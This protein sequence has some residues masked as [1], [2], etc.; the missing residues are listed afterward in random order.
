[1]NCQLRGKKLEDAL[2][3]CILKLAKGQK[4]YILNVTEVSRVSGIS[5][6][7]IYSHRQIIDETL[8]EI[9]ASR[10]MS[11]GH[12]TLEHA[13]QKITDLEQQKIALEEQI[14]GYKAHH[15]EIYNNINRQS[16]DARLLISEVDASSGK[17]PLCRSKLTS[18]N[19][20][21]QSNIVNLNRD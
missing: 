6:Q 2:V 3:K 17:C 9:K 18:T 7:S 8:E 5:R 12:A 11:D 20:E 19:S 10:R 21:M 16:I 14:E 1:M 4:N 13:M 15:I